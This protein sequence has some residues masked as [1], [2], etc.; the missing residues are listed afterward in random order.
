[1]STEPTPTRVQQI[2]PENPPVFPC[3]IHVIGGD[4]H[5]T[6]GSDLDCCD[7]DSCDYWHPDQSE[8]PTERPDAPKSGYVERCNRC[9]E[10]FQCWH[11]QGAV[12]ESKACGE[13]AT[14]SPTPET[15]ALSEIR[16]LAEA[17]RRNLRRD[18]AEN[19]RDD[20]WVTT[21]AAHALCIL[22]NVELLDRER[23]EVRRELD[24]ARTQIEA[25][26]N[27]PVFA[28]AEQDAILRAELA[29]A[30]RDTERLDW[31]LEREVEI[32]I[33]REGP[34]DIRYRADIDAA[35]KNG[36]AK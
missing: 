12:C 2:T 3:W 5:N 22:D 8:A 34:T 28:I 4:W 25:W 33:P 16:E 11:M 32:Y 23:D 13:P 17:I 27:T 10:R 1:M 7:M 26:K 21:A 9:E 36:G 19:L 15:D 18:I 35:R 6:D 14:P 31:L 30:K 20:L 29:E 24:A